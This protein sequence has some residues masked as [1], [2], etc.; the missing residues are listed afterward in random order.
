MLTRIPNSPRIA[1]LESDN[2]RSTAWVVGRALVTEMVLSDK[3]IRDEIESGRIAITPFSSTDVQPASVD[4]HLD[5]KVLVFRNSTAPYVDLRKDLPNLN[6]MVVIEDDQPFILHPGEFVLGNTL[7]RISLSD[8]IVARLEGKSSLGRIGLLDPLDGW[9]RGPG[10]GW[11]FDPRVVER[12]A[13]ALDAL[14]GHADRA[15]LV[16]VPFDTGGES[17]RIRGVEEPISRADG[18]D[19]VTSAPRI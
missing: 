19:G 17:I 3:S 1:K 15:D 4:L 13:V 18:A 2:A 11:T 9:L 8:S 7:E 14:Q 16:S 10:V 5:D 12:F 6:E